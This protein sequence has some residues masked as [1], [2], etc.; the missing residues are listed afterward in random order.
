MQQPGDDYVRKIAVFIRNNERSLAQL[1]F[2]VRRRRQQQ[3]QQAQHSDASILNPLSWLGSAPA[4]PTVLSIDTHH[5][6]YILIRLEALGLPIGS[7]DVRVESPSRPLSYINLFPDSDKSDTLSLSSIRS[8]LSVVSSLSLGAGWWSQ[9]PLESELKYIYS[10][11]TKLPA[12]SITAPGPKVIVE[13]ANEPPNSNAIPLDS[14]KNLQ[15]L[16]CFDI[17]PRSLLGWDRLA[18]GLISLKIKKSGLEDLTEVFIGAVLDDQARREGSSS[19]KRVR[20]IPKGPAR[21]TSFYAT[22]LPESV[23]EAA[24]EDQSPIAETGPTQSF[25]SPSATPQLPSYKWSS[26]R[27]LSLSD[28][29]LTFFPSELIPY[30]KTVSHLDLS[31]NLLVSVPQGLGELYNLIYLNLSDNMI[32]SVLGI[33]Q[34]LGLVLHLNLSHNRLESICGLE[35]LHALEKI[36]LRGNVIEES[37]EI[38]RLATLPNISDIWVEGNPFTEYEDNYRVICF[39]FFW[40]EGK[41]VNLDGNPPGFYEKRHLTQPPPEQMSSSRP[42]STAPSPPIIAVGHSHAHHTPTPPPPAEEKQS[43]SEISP[44]LEPLGAVGVSS[45]ARRKKAK[46][47]V[48]LDGEHSDDGMKASVPKAPGHRRQTSDGSKYRMKKKEQVA[49]S[50]GEAATMLA[51]DKPSPRVDEAQSLSTDSQSVTVSRPPNPRSQRSRHGR[52]QSEYTPFSLD[53]TSPMQPPPVPSLRRPLDSQTLRSNSSRR[54]R[55]TSSVYDPPIGNIEEAGEDATDDAE[56]FRRRIEALK[57]D[58][59]D[60]W[61]KVFS[62]T[63]VKTPS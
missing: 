10:S 53:D 34:N 41:S 11:F 33:Y 25:T 19:R 39:D 14:F 51:A 59:G 37:G 57:K 36:D 17:D 52:V 55:L 13:L 23:P 54:A 5:L 38:G 31:S 47:I 3:Q 35:R 58:M 43:S 16:E 63:Q 30:L 15:S 62:Q 45:K 50:L 12:L 9:P 44:P 49:N 1:P 27:H 6:F 8:S 20:R 61:L 28:N 32:D 22:Q 48:E 42:P 18:D 21:E 26:L 56:A 46:R 60:G 7:L 2:Q 29:S 40:K 4:K 24:D